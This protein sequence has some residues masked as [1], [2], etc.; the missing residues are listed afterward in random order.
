MNSTALLASG[1]AFAELRTT[2]P[3]N[4]LNLISTIFFLFILYFFVVRFLNG[5]SEETIRF[6]VGRDRVHGGKWRLN[7]GSDDRCLPFPPCYP[8]VAEEYRMTGLVR[9][10]IHQVMCQTVNLP[11]NQI[12][13]P[14][15]SIA[16][17]KNHILDSHCT[18]TFV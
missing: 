9:R 11:A 12:S 4:H 5:C 1:G 15:P 6:Y 18:M 3:E 10:W 14:A 13:S 17:Y 2:G 16:V 7:K 8:S